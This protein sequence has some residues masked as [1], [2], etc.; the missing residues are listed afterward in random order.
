MFI[1]IENRNYIFLPKLVPMH[2]AQKDSYMLPYETQFKQGI[3]Y[4]YV[5]R[6]LLHFKNYQST[7]F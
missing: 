7:I 6:K 2:K 5:G 1:S 3:L 4:M